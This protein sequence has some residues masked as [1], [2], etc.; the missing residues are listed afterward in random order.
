MLTTQTQVFYSGRS[1]LSL[2]ISRNG[3]FAVLAP[4]LQK[5]D[6]GHMT[7]NWKEAR[8]TKLSISEITYL[9]EG[10]KAYYKEGEDAYKKLATFLFGKEEYKNVQFIHVTAKG[11]KRVGLDSFGGLS[12]IVSEGK[13]NVL[14]YPI[15]RMD[16]FRLLEFLDKLI[17]LGFYYESI[18]ANEERMTAL[19]K[20]PPALISDDTEE[21]KEEKEPEIKLNF[22]LKLVEQA[23]S[24]ISSKTNIEKE[25]LSLI[26]EKNLT[27]AEILK[28]NELK[29]YYIKE[30]LEKE[31]AK[32]NKSGWINISTQKATSNQALKKNVKDSF[33]LVA[34]SADTKNDKEIALFDKAS[35]YIDTYQDLNFDVEWFSNL[36]K[37]YQSNIKAF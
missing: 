1:A 28:L 30:L 5:N 27:E 25:I 9:K 19:N 13:N 33:E 22:D 24:A 18:I 17:D 36:Y 16:L 23:L 6:N 26:S 15:Q 2:E 35:K 12:F 10:I 37:E 29:D 11:Q 7:F 34:K 4:A 32:R 14:R 31:E 21:I 3:I 8:I 20:I